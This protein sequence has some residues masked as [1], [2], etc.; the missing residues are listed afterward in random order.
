VSEQNDLQQK[1]LE[2]IKEKRASTA[3]YTKTLQSHINT[4]TNISI[5]CAAVTAVMT[6]GPAIGRD[7]F[8]TLVSGIINVPD[9]A[10]WGVLCLLAMVLSVT[11][12]I[13]NNMNRSQD[14]ATRLAKAQTAT[15]LFDKLTVSIEIKQI[16]DTDAAKLYQEYLGDISFIP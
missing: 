13:V 12:A 11:A 1:L 4:L 10:V 2:M 15:L 14:V 9:S 3:S 16:S 7:K 6:A 8:T 5:V